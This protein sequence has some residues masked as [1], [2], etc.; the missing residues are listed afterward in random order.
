MMKV[1]TPPPII[2]PIGMTATV[3]PKGSL[4]YRGERT[5]IEERYG[6][7]DLCRISRRG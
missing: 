5:P 4:P 6:R 3:R 2:R 7:K 1:G